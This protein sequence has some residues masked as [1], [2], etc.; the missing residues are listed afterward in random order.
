MLPQFKTRLTT[1]SPKLAAAVDVQR[2]LR[3]K[4][5]GTGRDSYIYSNNGGFSVHN[6]GGMPTNSNLRFKQA[7]RTYQVD[8]T[9]LSRYNNR[10]KQKVQRLNSSPAEKDLTVDKPKLATLTKTNGCLETLNKP[11]FL[12]SYEEMVGS[13]RPNKFQFQLQPN[14]RNQNNE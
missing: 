10:S 1:V 2:P 6:D 4:N 3:Y 13:A 11:S 9:Y 5:N 8:D 12:T 7:L 14:S